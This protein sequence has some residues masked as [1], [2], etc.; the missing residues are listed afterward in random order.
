MYEPFRETKT[1]QRWKKMD[2][3]LPEELGSAPVTGSIKEQ[4]VRWLEKK[5]KTIRAVIEW[6]LEG[7]ITRGRP[8]KRWLDVVEENQKALGV[9]VL[10]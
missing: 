5:I 8:R 4:S 2:N 3:E 7:K 10:T 6:K 1:N 9:Q